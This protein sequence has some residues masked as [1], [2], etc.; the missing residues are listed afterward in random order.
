MAEQSNRT[1][2][3]S[4]AFADGS[5]V[6][7]VYDAVAE[8][9]KLALRLPDGAL[10]LESEIALPSGE[11]LVPYAARNNLLTSGCVLL[12]SEIGAAL[13][14]ASLI[15]SIKA[16]IAAYVE[17]T[18]LFVDLATYYVLLSWVHDAFSELGYLRFQGAFGS[19]KTRALLVIGSLCYKPIFASGA[20]TVSPLFHLLHEF[21]GTLVLDEADLRFSDATADLTKILNN[22][23]V[24]G[25]PVLRTMTNRHRELNP[26]AFKVYGPK[27]I[28]M[29]ESFQD[30]ALESRFLTERTR[31]RAAHSAIPIHL[32][33]SQKSEALA[34][35]GKLLRWRFDTRHRVTI[36]PAR[37]IA[38]LSPRGNQSVLALLSLIDNAELRAALGTHLTAAEA[39]GVNRRAQ[40]PPAVMVGVLHRRFAVQDATYVRLADATTDYNALVAANGN[41]PL[42]IKATGYLIRIKLGL[43]TAKSNGVYVV[44]AHEKAKVVELAAR[45][46]SASE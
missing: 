34:L 44:P 37:A 16:H 17:L 1:P 8:Q 19:G 45:Y 18:P 22:G 24:K 20:S 21:G 38:S 36:D 43:A 6:E 33:D 14:K 40:L 9:T 27:L 10:S 12:P 23:T 2:T 35:R 3:I 30:E 29:R 46:P 39:L 4:R 28:A 41:C 26:Q 15:E 13:S 31:V 5:L 7:L 32:P 11:L 25:L 42:S